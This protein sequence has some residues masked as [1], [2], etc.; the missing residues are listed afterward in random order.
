VE[1][2]KAEEP[3]NGISPLRPKLHTAQK[4]WSMEL[5]EKVPLSYNIYLSAA[6]MCFSI[7]E[8]T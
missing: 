7:F 4:R 2:A 1:L 3:G 8:G 6:R 5:R